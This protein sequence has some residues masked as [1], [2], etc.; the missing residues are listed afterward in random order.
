MGASYV[1]NQIPEEELIKKLTKAVQAVPGQG[2][3]EPIATTICYARPE[4]P[5]QVKCYINKIG[6][7]D[8][9]NK[10][11]T[12]SSL[13]DY[14]KDAKNLFKKIYGGT[15]ETGDAVFYLNKGSVIQQV[16]IKKKT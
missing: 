10:G 6:G 16:N 11:V 14:E 3:Y 8:V 15:L 7:T 12:I 5:D 13:N 2:D 9:Y 4:A 1:N